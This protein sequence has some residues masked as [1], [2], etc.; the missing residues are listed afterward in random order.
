MMRYGAIKEVL[1][2]RMVNKAPFKNLELFL[3]S[4]FSP[5][6]ILFPKAIIKCG[7]FLGHLEL[8]LK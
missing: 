3:L 4:N 8:N 1:T 7:N 5:K 6:E 2:N